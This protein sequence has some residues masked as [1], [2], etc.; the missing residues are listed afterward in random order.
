[1]FMLDRGS[2][3]T[4]RQYDNN[5]ST[6]QAAP[7]AR[8]E[9][10]IEPPTENLEH[11]P[12]ES[13]QPRTPNKKSGL[14]KWIIAIAVTVILAAAG[15]FVYS[16]ST[17]HD[18]GIDKDKYQA[19]FLVGGQVY[20]GR[21]EVVDGNYLK[22]LDV[23]YPQLSATNQD[24]PTGDSDNINNTSDTSNNSLKLTKLG[25]EIHGPEDKM[26]VNRQQVLFIENLKPDSKVVQLIKDHKLGNK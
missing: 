16:K 15:W 10:L 5:R 19:V 7:T 25:G 22:L 4:P 17:N 1:M 8:R 2:A 11:R 12:V 21:L 9:D 20:F 3:R 23:F 24:S 6:Q 18:I 13:R 26:I 14:V